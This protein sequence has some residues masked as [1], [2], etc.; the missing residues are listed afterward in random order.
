MHGGRLLSKRFLAAVPKCVC[1]EPIVP[2]QKV[3]WSGFGEKIFA[4]LMAI[5]TTVAP[6]S[7][8]PVFI[9]IRMHRTASAII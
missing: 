7:N 5:G 2:F 8:A 3:I 6:K 9:D 1:E 4:Y